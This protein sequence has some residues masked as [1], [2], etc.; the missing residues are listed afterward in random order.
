M[1]LS[2]QERLL[3]HKKAG[4]PI[5]GRGAPSN[6]DGKEG[7]TAYRTLSGVG[8]VHY[9]K[10]NGEWQALSST[11]RMPAERIR[12]VGGGA[13]AGVTD[14]GSMSGLSD[15]D[16]TQYLLVDGTR[17]VTGDLSLSG[18]DGAL[19]FT[20]AGENSIKIPDNQASAL[21][22]EEANNA[23]LTFN[24][25]NSGGEKITLGKK[26]EAGS[27]EI[28]GTAFDINGGTVDA[29][30]SLTV[31]N[32]VDVGNYKITSKALEA[33][34]LTSGR[35]TF[36][37]SNG[38]LSDDSDF[39]F[40]TDTL[41][42]T[43]IGAFEATGA[44]D[45]SDENMTNVDIDSGAIDGTT[46]GSSSHT[47]IKG[48]TIDATTDFTIGTLVITDDQIQMSPSVS[49][50]VTIS[51]A[52]NGVLNITTLDAAAAAA[53]IVVTADGTL[54]L[55]SV[56]LDV[57]ASGAV[58]IDGAT[59]VAI[60]GASTS[61]YG[62]DVAVWSFN[63]SGAVSE[64]GMTTFSLTPSG[65]TVILSG[66]ALELDAQEI[67]IG[68][69]NDVPIEID[70][71]TFDL[72]A[73][74]NITIDGAGVSIDSSAASNF[75][76]SGGALTL[77][78]AAAATWSTAAGNLTIDSAAGTLV[79]D[80]HTGV[81]IDASNSGKVAIDGAGGIDIGVASDVAIDVDASTLDIDTSDEITI[82]AG[83]SSGIS[84]DASAASN[85]TT[86]AGAILID[87]AAST[88]TVDGHTGVTVQSTNSGNITL[89]SVAD[90]TLSADGDQI[91]MDDGSTT[92][93][94]FNVDSTPELDVTGNFIL[95]GS[96]TIQL[97]AAGNLITLTSTKVHQQSPYTLGGVDGYM[98]RIDG[99]GQMFNLGDA[100]F[101]AN[102]SIHT[103]HDNITS[104]CDTSFADTNGA[105]W[106]AGA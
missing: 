101:I 15:D 1:A 32:N 26:L 8:T 55:N 74:S 83:S 43:K 63:G 38:L 7:E 25:A 21:I 86:S 40:A 12:I 44:I 70:A 6:E 98:H 66:A 71:T 104:T 93:F 31:A 22:I 100:D 65:D 49:D 33:S 58:T 42:V 9:I 18:G 53:N 73:T 59:T 46:I 48:T 68:N 84:L 34:D 11:D 72:D 105:G 19:T 54:D 91:T 39:T 41:T 106:E 99:I 36:A 3:L 95:D 2:R 81:N 45:F 94:T 77:T 96:G 35:V 17:A 62:D 87:A 14:H 60:A 5:S 85:F 24:T 23:Y 16:H 56:A 13:G 103:N 75:T 29:I 57:D 50:T 69:D 10:K 30:T 52:T 28:E 80:G 102:Y 90:I 51:A 88:V 61:T 97:D 27:V 76:T 82:D 47:T 37:G 79:L 67:T 89:D 92:R 20:V 4:V 78:S 64:T